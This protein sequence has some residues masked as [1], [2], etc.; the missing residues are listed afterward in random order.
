MKQPLPAFDLSAAQ[1][2]RLQ[3]FAALLLDWNRRI[4]LISRSDAPRLWQRHILDS[5]QLAPLLPLPAGTLIDFGS[6]AGFPGL[7]LAAVTGWCAHLVEADGRKAAF[8]REAARL[9][10]AD[11][12]IH[13]TRAERLGGIT[14]QAV[15]ARAFAP[16]THL[17]PLAVPRLA[18]DG[19]CL[20]PKG[21]SA[22]DELTAARREWH[23]R[24]EC[25]QSRTSP[26]ATV[27]RLHDLRPASA[28]G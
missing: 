10:G 21:Q 18:E 24:V 6:G 23:M 13:T 9:L 12:V 17:L 16:L 27:L 8:L 19:V 11:A 2:E 20:F 22:S 5:A 28:S 4:N 25:F 14:A 15:T 26:A 3:G 7:V 1:S